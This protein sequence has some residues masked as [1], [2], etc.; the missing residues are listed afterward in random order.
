V[1]VCVRACVHVLA[2]VVAWVTT[3]GALVYTIMKGQYDL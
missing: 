3:G 2:P 1:C